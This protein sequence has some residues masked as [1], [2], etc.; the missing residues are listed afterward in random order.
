MGKYLRIYR[1]FSGGL[2]E[3]AN[4]NIKD[5]ELVEAR[6]IMP[7]DGFGIAKASGVTVAYPRIPVEQSNLNRV[8]R[9]IRFKP[10]NKDT[11]L[12]AFVSVPAVYEDLYCYDEA[13]Q[14][15]NKIAANELK[16]LD[17]FITGTGLYW[18]NGQKLRVY[19]GS[20]VEDAQLNPADSQA[21]A[22]EQAVWDRINTAVAVE[23]RGQRWFFATADNEVIFTRVGD[24]TSVDITGI[25]N[26]NTKNGDSITALHE[27]NEGILI[28]KKHSVHYLVG[29]DF[30]G[31]SDVQL[32]QLNVSSGTAFPK[33]ICTVENAVLYLGINGIYRLSVPSNSTVV[34]SRNISRE[35][36]SRKLC[37]T[38]TILDAFAVVW[39]NTYH[40]TLRKNMPATE[41]TDAVIVDHEYRYLA[42]QDSFFGEFTQETACYAVG[43]D[44]ENGLFIGTENGYVLRYD[45]NSHSYFNGASEEYIPIPC[46]AATKCYDVAGAMAQEV[47]I[48]RVE[49]AV[50][51]YAEE[52]SAFTMA[53][54]AD[55]FGGFWDT[56]F[57]WSISSDE[58]LIYGDGLLGAD[59]WGWQDTV[60]KEVVLRRRCKRLQFIISDE[61]AD[62]PLLIYGLAALYRRKRVKGS[63]RGVDMN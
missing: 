10:P 61:S 51:Q 28:F 22:E 20:T 32:I 30:D 6:N 8:C 4:D 41:D 24:P 58:S 11:Q 33:S 16:V 46:Y 18:L 19:D 45:S 44:G 48:D 31:G 35:K 60:I 34:A 26:I 50:R 57:G 53:V 54:R 39:D 29:W 63:R 7:G 25:I 2:S 56:S 5:N 43:L 52:N 17:W 55:H 49:I 3:A 9:L 13:E 37:E 62:Q 21:T 27:F 15:W 14:S 1:D 59:R 23:Q 40:I 42:A 12:L 47:R 36:V 38:G